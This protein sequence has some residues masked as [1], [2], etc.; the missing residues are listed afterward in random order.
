MS[1]GYL[2]SHEVGLS[3]QVWYCV[4]HWKRLHLTAYKL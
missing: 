2:I 3:P 1:T 4:A